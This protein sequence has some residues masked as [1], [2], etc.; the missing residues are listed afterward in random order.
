[1]PEPD[2]GAAGR[3]VNNLGE[4]APAMLFN[5]INGYAD[6]RDAL[7]VIG[8]WPNHALMLGLPKDTPVKEQFYEFLRRWKQ[9]PVPIVRVDHAPFHENVSLPGKEKRKAPSANLRD[10]IQAGAVCR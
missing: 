7:N 3:A 10:N 9:F 2:L 1:M 6:A 8:S 4:Y 5:R